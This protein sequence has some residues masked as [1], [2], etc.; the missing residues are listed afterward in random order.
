MDQA[1]SF[2]P[3]PDAPQLPSFPLLMTALM[4]QLK[5]ILDGFNRTLEHLSREVG[6]LSHDLARLKQERE[7]RDRTFGEPG[8]GGVG[9]FEGKLDESLYQLEQVRD[10][11]RQQRGELED[12]IHSQQ[13]M[14]HYNLTNFKT[15]TD[16]KIKRSQKMIQVSV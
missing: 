13:A 3:F 16:V 8:T 12:R 10:E 15:E 1:P 11:L 2:S 6:G 9:D 14:L 5:P 4:A 7:D